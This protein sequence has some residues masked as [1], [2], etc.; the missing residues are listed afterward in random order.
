MNREIKFRVWDKNNKKMRLP[1]EWEVGIVLDG[2]LLTCYDASGDFNASD[3][4]LILMQYTGLKDKNGV[5]IYE[6]D[7]VA[8]DGMGRE[9]VEFDNG[10]FWVGLKGELPAPLYAQMG[11]DSME[12]VGNIHENPEL[13]DK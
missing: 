5:E 1:D 4:D 6:G 9:V 2:T 10:C 8:Y 12:V 11:I 3:E 7:V 13:L